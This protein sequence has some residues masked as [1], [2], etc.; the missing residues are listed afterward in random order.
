MSHN[1]M[2][3]VKMQP[4]YGLIYRHRALGEKR[5]KHR[6]MDENIVKYQPKQ[7]VST[8]SGGFKVKTLPSFS[9]GRGLLPGLRWGLYS[10]TACAQV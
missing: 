3:R 6:V 1:T 8:I 4:L 7:K 10:R 5:R 2:R 9:A